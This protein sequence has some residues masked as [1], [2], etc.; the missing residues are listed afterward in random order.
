MTRMMIC[1]IMSRVRPQTAPEDEEAEPVADDEEP[2]RGEGR[3]KRPAEID[4]P[5]CL[6]A[7]GPGV[8][9]V[10]TS[11]RRSPA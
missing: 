2:G 5:E 8:R 3:A 6:A 10:F 9:A 11:C 4:A 1:E 7:R